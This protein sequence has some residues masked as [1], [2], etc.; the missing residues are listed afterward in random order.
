MAKANRVPI[1]RTTIRVHLKN[2]D[3]SILLHPDGAV[4]IEEG[5]TAILL[6]ADEMRETIGRTMVHHS[7]LQENEDDD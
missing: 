2:S 4:E 5:S 3:I 1:G 6:S 7:D